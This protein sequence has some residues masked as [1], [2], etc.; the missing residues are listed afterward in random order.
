MILVRTSWLQMRCDRTWP[1]W[2]GSSRCA[3]F[4]LSSTATVTD[5]HPDAWWLVMDVDVGFTCRVCHVRL[6]Q[7]TGTAGIAES[8]AVQ[9]T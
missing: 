7:T 6:G 3:D 8:S 5:S 2:S 9:Y 4:R 1:A